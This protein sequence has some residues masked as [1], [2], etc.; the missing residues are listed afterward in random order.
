MAAIKPTVLVEGDRSVIFTWTNVTNADTFAGE[1]D[2]Q[3]LDFADRSFQVSGTFD[4]ATVSIVGSNDRTTYAI[5]HD[6]L[7]G[8]ASMTAAGLKQIYE[9]ARYMRPLASGGAGSQSVTVI[10]FC[11]RGPSGRGV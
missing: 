2:S 11:R 4:S 1:V 7:G 9:S 5:L 8:N 10:L 3:F 6:G